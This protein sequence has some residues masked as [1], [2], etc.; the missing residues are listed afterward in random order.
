MK[1]G[2]SSSYPS[3]EYTT[4]HTPKCFFTWPNIWSDLTLAGKHSSFHGW[5][6]FLTRHL[7]T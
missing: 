7:F 2:S 3:T 1:N 5:M 6:L 4:P